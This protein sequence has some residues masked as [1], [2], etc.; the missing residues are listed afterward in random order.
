MTNRSFRG[1]ALIIT[2]CVAICVFVALLSSCST[3]NAAPEKTAAPAEAVPVVPVAKVGR[4]NLASDLVLT[5]EF[6]P[7]Q[8]IDVMAKVAGYVQSINVDIGDRVREGQVLATLEIPEMEDELAK[9]AA[10][11]D[12]AE[13]EIVTAS[14][15]LTRAQAA[16]ELAHISYT[17]I[18]D[19]I[20]KEPGLVPQQE[21][22]EA[23][24]RDLVAEAQVSAATSS[25]KTAEQKARVARADQSRL[26]T[27]HKYTTI[28]APFDGVVT[29]RY[30]N[31]GSMIQAGT[32]S[33]TQAMP[34]VQ[35]SQ[36][37]LL[38][39]ILPAPESVV[40]HIHVG[41]TLDVKVTSLGKTFPG[42]VARFA[43]KIQE[44]TRTMDTEVDVPNPTLTLI[45]GMYA[46]VTLRVDGRDNVL[47]LPLDAV[48]RSGPSPRVYS[49][50]PAGV[51]HIVPVTLGLETDQ[52][53]E[54]RSGL[55]EGDTVVVG[56]LSGLL[57]G[58]P[59][60]IRSLEAQVH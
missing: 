20:K 38:R 2:V 6:E 45:P 18:G 37:N 13:A 14:D 48:D 12:Q 21:V 53:I 19:V 1:L 27:L 7:Y 29:K 40:S 3:S 58:Q 24:S 30:A 10:S 28:P 11:I 31:T 32:A 60:Q 57:E 17:R 59:V 56:R 52:W 34:V 54:V 39:L 36:N 25:L 47:A 23:R 9:A 51:I 15:E 42:R 26:Q 35:L 50:T 49:V 46:E 43:D 4:E 5:A 22:D 16:H 41:E 44:S 33:Q 55:Q 8:Q